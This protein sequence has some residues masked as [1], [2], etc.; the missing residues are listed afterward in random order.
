MDQIKEQLSREP[1][2]FPTLKLNPDITDIDDFSFDDFEL[3]DYNPHK[4]LR[5]D[6]ANIGGFEDSKEKKFIK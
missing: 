4:T 5:A 1:K 6:I 2:P 3:V